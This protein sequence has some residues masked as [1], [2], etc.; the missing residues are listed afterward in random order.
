MTRRRWLAG[1]AGLLL[2][3]GL[4]VG[5]LVAQPAAPF[6]FA[7][8][9]S[10]LVNNTLRYQPGFSPQRV[11]GGCES[12]RTGAG[13]VN[14]WRLSGGTAGNPITLTAFP[15]ATGDANI[16][17]SLVPA[18]TGG[19]SFTGTGT[20]VA[21]RTFFGAMEACR[22]D[23]ALLIPTR[24]AAGDFAL[25]RTAAGAETYNVNC[26]F[27]LPFQLTANKGARIDSIE[28]SYQV[29]TVALTT[30]TFGNIRT[31]TFANN[32][33]NAIANYAG[34]SAA[35][36]ATATQAN[37]YYTTVTITAP[38]FMNLDDTEVN[39]EW[40]AVMANTGVYRVYGIMVN[41]TQ[42]LF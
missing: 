24:I 33:A 19:V 20:Q 40:Q 35:T 9:P 36:L 42:A 5:Y 25:A 31:R 6:Y 23:N 22:A 30:H 13:A 32:V 1:L 2:A 15:C 7:L 12:E 3:T 37:P 11:E 34:G 4:G 21:T 26:T 29:L 28:V 16:G 27:K 39:I 14:G 8:S 38:V 10:G 17:I 18:G 41:W